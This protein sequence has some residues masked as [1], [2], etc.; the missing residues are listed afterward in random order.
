M[1]KPDTRRARPQGRPRKAL[2]ARGLPSLSP[3]QRL[4]DRTHAAILEAICDGTLAP[5]ERVTQ[6]A[7]AARLG[8]SRQPVGQ[9]LGLL[10]AR[11]FLKETGRRGLAVAH[12]DAGFFAAIYELRSAIEPAA[13]RLAAHKIT[14][15][16]REE[17]RELLREG[18]QVLRTGDLRALIRADTRF[19]AY[20]YRLSGNPL[21]GEVMDQ[22]W[23][24]LRRAMGEVLRSRTEAKRVWREHASILA[25]LT[26]Q[27]G[28]LAARRIRAHL[29]SAAERVLATL[30]R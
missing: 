23:M 3:Q 7:I 16:D 1:Q 22:Y 6:E 29:E 19:H 18:N 9:A 20:I 21:F 5:G 28:D 10:K 12:L 14:D 24:H 27:D 11:G 2:N 13:A 30:R 15:S 17:G 25:A 26:D 8:V 4:L